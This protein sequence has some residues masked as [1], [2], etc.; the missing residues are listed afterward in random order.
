VKL[1]ESIHP[2]VMAVL[3]ASNLIDAEH[4]EKEV[5]QLEKENEQLKQQIKA[6]QCCG[7]C[8][9]K[10]NLYG[11]CNKECEC[12]NYSNWELLE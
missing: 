4:F 7:N 10:M 3:E 12:I 1:S 6:M 11:T 8:N 2:F 9:H 5:I